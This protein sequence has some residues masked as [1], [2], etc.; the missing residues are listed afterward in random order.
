MKYQSSRVVGE[1]SSVNFW[2]R[3]IY[4]RNVSQI[5]RFRTEA[6]VSN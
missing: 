1:V 6:G 2:N 5:W 3:Q 4:T